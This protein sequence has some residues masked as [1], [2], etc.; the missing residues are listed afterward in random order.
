MRSVKKHAP[1]GRVAAAVGAIASCSKPL[2]VDAAAVAK[3]GSKRK[4]RL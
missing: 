4:R 2:L 3:E 1:V